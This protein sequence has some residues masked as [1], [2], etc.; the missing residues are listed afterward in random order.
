MKDNYNML[1][2]SD[3]KLNIEE[4]NRLPIR[5]SKENLGKV[6]GEDTRIEVLDINT[7][8]YQAI[9]RLLIKDQGVAYRGTG[10]MIYNGVMLTAGHNIYDFETKRYSDEIQVI[11]GSTVHQMFAYKIDENYVK[12]G[13]SEYDWAVVK[14]T[15][16]PK[17]AAKTID[18]L[19]MDLPE[20]PNLK[21]V[22][23]EIAGF[24][25]IVKGV[26][27]SNMF[28]AN[29]TIEEDNQAEQ[30]LHYKISTSGGNSGSPIIIKKEG[31]FFAVGIHVSGN[32]YF[33]TAK[34]IDT[35]IINA[36]QEI[37]K[38]EE[39]EKT[40]NIGSNKKNLFFTLEQKIQLKYCESE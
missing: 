7:A 31:T 3:G 26:S 6:F 39:I 9:V 19:Q 4:Y 10:F 5:G 1:F 17:T 21:G 33:N 8:P 24:P 35:S 25:V 40:T 18:Y 37:K 32:T 11:N 36:I 14:V 20:S 29:G 38:M 12:S 34:A 28:T 16:N 23:G 13:T 27:T 15:V 22:N 30:V 2:D